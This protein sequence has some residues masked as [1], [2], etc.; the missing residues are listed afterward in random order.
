MHIRSFAGKA[1]CPSRP[2]VKD[3]ANGSS[4]PLLPG[5]HIRS[6]LPKSASSTRSIFRRYAS[7]TAYAPSS[8][9]SIAWPRK[10]ISRP[11]AWSSSSTTGLRMCCRTIASVK[12]RTSSRQSYAMSGSPTANSH[13]VLEGRTAVHAL[14][15]LQRRR[16]DIFIKRPNNDTVCETYEK[17]SRSLP[18]RDIARDY[19]RADRRSG[20]ARNSAIAAAGNGGATM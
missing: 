18:R 7:S 19:T 10:C 13:T 5:V 9:A 11:K 4:P 6:E 16:P 3:A 15:N 2:F 8:R 1:F 14:K 17:P 12:A 20:C